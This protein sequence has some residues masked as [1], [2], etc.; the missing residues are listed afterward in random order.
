MIWIS[1]G[2]IRYTRDGLYF[3]MRNY[4]Y[5]EMGKYPPDPSTNTAAG[6][7]SPSQAAPHEK[8]MDFKMEIDRRLALC[9]VD[10]KL[11]LSE[12]R[13]GVPMS[14]LSWECVCV[15]NYI[16]WSPKVDADMWQIKIDGG[17]GISGRKQY[18]AQWKADRKYKHKKALT[19]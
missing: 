14:Y 13:R 9:G 3:L 8:A 17:T 1:P 12:C 6:Y 16:S 7:H 5:L 4:D 15:L 18:Y 19:K 10:G 2:D 11:L